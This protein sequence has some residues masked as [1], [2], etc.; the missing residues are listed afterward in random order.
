MRKADLLKL[1]IAIIIMFIISLP[2]FFQ[3]QE[4]SAIIISCMDACSLNNITFPLCGFNNSYE[5]FLR[6]KRKNQTVFLKAFVN[7]SNI[8]NIPSVCQVSS[9]EQQQRIVNSEVSRVNGSLEM[10]A[11]D[12][13]FVYKH[14]NFTVAH[15]NE[16][17]EEFN[18]YYILEVQIKK[19]T[20]RRGNTTDENIYYSCIT[21]MMEDQ[22]DCINISLQLTSFMEN[23]MCPLKILWFVLLP[24]VF[25]LTVIVVTFK[26]FQENKKHANSKSTRMASV[27]LQKEEYKHPGESTATNGIRL[28][29][30]ET[31]QRRPSAN[32]QA[33]KILPAIPEQEFP[34]CSATNIS[35]KGQ[36]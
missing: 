10:K 30:E 14:F 28:L 24:L 15:E 32:V 27:I 1:L 34:H 5:S 11:K 9:S 33:T 12:F 29:S 16:E 21:A 18:T 19:S 20:S 22:N 13:I 23:P 25:V 35:T 36:I 8:Q 7:Q 31:H 2:E 6:H 4:E 26:V 3:I 17:S